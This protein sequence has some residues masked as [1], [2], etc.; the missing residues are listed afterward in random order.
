MVVLW[1]TVETSSFPYLCS[2]TSCFR[3]LSLNS[4]FIFFKT[5]KWVLDLKND[6]QFNWGVSCWLHITRVTGMSFSHF[7]RSENKS[8][9]TDIR[10]LSVVYIPCIR[11]VS[12]V[13]VIKSRP[14]TDPRSVLGVVSLTSPFRR[15]SFTDDSTLGLLLRRSVCWSIPHFQGSV[16][17]GDSDV[18][19]TLPLPLSWD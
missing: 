19:P 2:K 17:H 7:F 18:V 9:L 11:L 1:G 4:V 13:S 5:L 14:Y 16:F 6:R 15:P 12:G 10:P 8:P 3:S